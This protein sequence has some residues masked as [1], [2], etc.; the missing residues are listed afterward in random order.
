MAEN[1]N[2]SAEPPE[3]NVASVEVPNGADISAKEEPVDQTENTAAQTESL[4]ATDAAETT[5]PEAAKIA[6]PD[7][8]KTTEPDSTKTVE[9]ASSEP[10][11]DTTKKASAAGS[12]TSGAAN[13]RKRKRLAQD[14]IGQ[15]E[16]QLE[17]NPQDMAAWT[18]LINDLKAKDN[19]EELRRIYERVLK[20]VPTSVE[21]WLDLINLELANAEFDRAKE[22]FVRSLPK[23]VHVKL[24]SAYIDFIR[25]TNSV[26]SDG[27]RAVATIME[28]YEFVLKRVKYDIGSGPLWA[29][30]IEFI[31]SRKPTVQWEQS[32]Q[33]DLLRKNF[34]EAVTIPLQNI[35]GLWAKYNTFENNISRATARKFIG[36]RS[37]AYMNARSVLREIQNILQGVDRSTTPHQRA[38]TEDEARTLAKWQRWIRFEKSNPLGTDDKELVKTRILYAYRQAVM[39]MRYFPELWFEAAEYAF[40]IDRPD[41][42]NE[43]LTDGI[44]ANPGS[45]LLTFKR[46]EALERE[47]RFEDMDKA[48]DALFAHFK[49][50][51]ERLEGRI[52]DAKEGTSGNGDG[53][54]TESVAALTRELER[55]ARDMTAV[56]KY[57]MKIAKRAR[58][59]KEARAVFKEHR[60]APYTTCDFWISSALMEYYNDKTK[61]IARRI[62]D[63]GLKRYEG[64]AE[65]IIEYFDFLVLT[66]D[67]TNARA[68]FEKAVT[69]MAPDVARPLYEHYLVYEAN[70]GELSSLTSLEQRYLELYPDTSEVDLFARR[71]NSG[72]STYNP[73]I[74][75]DFG[76]QARPAP[77][78]PKQATSTHAR[79]VSRH[80]IDLEP[81]R[82][83]RSRDSATPGPY[84]EHQSASSLPQSIISVLR[85]LPPASAYDT[86]VFDAT[87][88]VHLLKESRIPEEFL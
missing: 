25:R 52:E 15:L 23:V 33:T 74:D 31:N 49:K 20:V 73:I 79:K 2:S 50:Q 54:G 44:Q 61:P 1:G 84:V 87:K 88:L 43:F 71:F 62:F 38:Y 3:E 16:D 30:Y 76:Q 83:K 26:L 41:E 45:F 4:E 29:Q 13:R 48:F 14:V 10:Q 51:R 9:P 11:D 42:A 77:S 17:E 35:E 39:V 18:Q 75:R 70:Y 46:V 58:G 22:L 86:V 6:E 63:L 21:T 80:D 56:I 7:A 60:D 32:H 81:P 47:G 8:T 37:G 82:S 53:S 12:Q 36:D 27:D 65:Y 40:S 68:I 66:D 19:H 24:D 64:I 5:E 28:A 85:R 72:H 67:V 55:N 59:L 78:G 69:K 57:R 34:R